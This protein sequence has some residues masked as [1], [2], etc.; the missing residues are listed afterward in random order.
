MRNTSTL[1][2]TLIQLKL[3]VLILI[4]F[5]ITQ[6][7]SQQQFKRVYANSVEKSDNEYL[8]LIKAGYVDNQN[9]AVDG[10]TST[11]ATLNS[12]V[13]QLAFIKLGGEAFVDLR[14]TGPDKPSANTPLT[15]KLGIG[16]NLLTALG[17]I[18]IQPKNGTS[19]VGSPIYGTSLLN[20]LSGKNQIEFT[21]TPTQA[22]DG[23]R[24]KLG[25]TGGILSA[26]VA[27]NLDVYHAY[28]LKPATNNIICE[29][30][31]DSLYGSTGI[32]VGSLNPLEKASN[33][34]DND[35]NTFATLRTNVSALNS[36][37]LTGV[38]SSLSKKN[39]SIRLVIQQENTGLLDLSLL[40]AIRIKTYENNTLSQNF[41]LDPSLLTLKL[42]TGGNNKYL[43]TVPTDQ[44]FNRI[45]I[46]IGD[47]VANVLAGLRVYE[48]GK[49][50]P[51][52][53]I[54]IPGLVNGS[55][56]I[57][58]G[59]PVKF[60]INNP[61]NAATYKW[62][63]DAIGGNEITTTDVTE[64]GTVFSPKNLA[65]GTYNYYVSLYRNGCSDPAS[66]RSKVTLII[67]PG[68]KSTDITA[69][70]TAICIGSDAIIAK[71][72]LAN[73][74]IQNPIF[75]W[76]LDANKT[77]PITNGT[78]NGVTYTINSD[79]SLKIS[80]LTT[81][82]D[83]YLS[84]SGTNICENASGNLKN[85]TVTVNSTEQPIL[86]LSGIQNIGT[87]GTITLTATSSN[88][89]S[90][91]WFKD[92]VSIKNSPDNSLVITNAQASDAGTYRVTATNNTNCKS[93]TSATVTINIGGFGSTK[94]V[95][96]LVDG[97]INA[98]TE[99]IF[100]I[101][102]SNTGSTPIN[103]ATISDDIPTGTS[104]VSGSADADGGVLNGNTLN[105]DLSNIIPNSTKSVSFKVK[106]N[107]NLTAISSIKNI[108]IVTDLSDP[109]N[110]QTPTVPDINTN[111]IRKFESSKTVSGLIDGK[112][113]AGAILTYNI[114]IEN[115]G[116][117]DL[118][119]ISINDVIPNGTSYIDLSADLTGGTPKANSSE[120][121][122]LI[123]VPFGTSKT[124]SF[125]V[126]V[127]DNL[128]G[129]PSI[130]NTATVTDPSDPDNPQTPTDPPKDTDPSRSFTAEKSIS[131]LNADNK[132]SPES[133]LTFDIKVKNTGN[134]DLKNI[135]ITDPIPAG[136]T[137]IED[138]ASN[139]SLINGV[140]NWLI[141]IPYNT[142]K[143]VSFKVLVAKD[144]TGIPQ[145]R[146]KATVTD[147]LHPE[148]PEEPES[149]PTDTD[150]KRSYTSTKTVTGLN[151]GKIDAGSILTYTITLTN[152]GNISLPGLKINDPIPTGTT[153]IDESANL[154]GE[155]KNN[156]L[157]WVVDLPVN[158]K[159]ELTFN[160]RVSNDL[161]GVSSIGNTATVTD[162]NDGGKTQTAVSLPEPTNQKRSFASSKVV[163]GLNTNNKITAGSTLTYK[164]NVTNTGNVNL[165]GITISD[166]IPTGTTY[167]NNSAD[168]N[169]TLTGTDLKWTI[170]VPF[171]ETKTVIFSVK[172]STD[173]TGIPSIGNTAIVTDPNTPNIPDSPGSPGNP[174]NPSV[175]NTDTEQVFDFTITSSLTSSNANGKASPGNDL[176]VSIV[177]KN[178]GNT[179]LTGIV[180]TNP[181]PN[182]TTYKSVGSNGS[183]DLLTKLF[184]FNVASLAVD[185]SITLTFNIT[186]D[187]NLANVTAITSNT[188]VKANSVE[189][190]KVASI[191]VLCPTLAATT[192]TA[193]GSNGGTLCS[194]NNNS[195]E[196]KA[197]SSGLTN[198]VYYLYQNNA[199]VDN[200][201]TGI[202]SL[203]LTPGNTTYT[204]SVG[205]SGTGYCETPAVDRK[206]ISFT[207]NSTPNAPG[208]TASNVSA[209]E[210]STPVLSIS[211]PVQGYTYA[212]YLSPSGGTSQGTG[213]NFTAAAVTGNTSYYVEAISGTCTSPTR[214]E[215]KITM[216]AAPA[217]PTNISL[218]NGP[219]CNGS[220]ARLS[221]DNPQSG[222]IYRWYASLSGGTSLFEGNIYTTD[223]LTTKT[224]YYVESVSTTT[225]C[226]SKT[227]FAI[228]VDVLPALTA[229][230]VN[231]DSKTINSVTFKW[232][233]I[234]DAIS[235]E[236]STNSGTTWQSTNGLTSYTFVGLKPAEN[237]SILVR[238]LGTNSC[239][240]S[241]ASNPAI[242]NSD[243][244]LGNE[245]FIPNTFTPNND[246]N[247]DFFLIYGNTIKTV[248]MRI[249]NQWGQSIFQ[250]QQLTT[251]WDGTYKGQNQPVG[252]YIYNIELTFNDGSNT[253]KK[254]TITLIR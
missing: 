77:T 165:T 15:I 243:N 200:N 137:Y 54:A 65:P 22:Y 239:Q 86:N 190:D 226:A 205:I 160:V 18:T 64:N 164:I 171:G 131:G 206:S 139:G 244:P 237:V 87:G 98:N 215:V 188:N 189:K 201:S 11:F 203:T 192:V 123:D 163:E 230:N 118:K 80:G 39:D 116:N 149:P 152:T 17:G 30:V 153:Y 63:T 49:I 222:L 185:A 126:K 2:K 242:G 37:F 38:Y 221:V 72:V 124:V 228:E 155:V 127:A 145:I 122:W 151:S 51:S 177:L 91:E 78:I 121:N 236:F 73:I 158:E 198:P 234:K 141:D 144:L 99:L 93:I 218:T 135:S 140:L 125:Q 142:E 181:L 96:G 50:A 95:T 20:L 249:Y 35:D 45:R 173:L 162:P 84:V 136:T 117:V 94:S 24:I 231:V 44:P 103:S 9:N 132:I 207:I 219:L 27:A 85:I 6:T 178:T 184:T 246:G 25:N 120:V 67:T 172:V 130:G 92:D 193:N 68:A 16:G 106:V 194:T 179:S 247:N 56:T 233:N 175:P 253:V 211:T 157:D 208:V 105:W 42:L 166:P 161:T 251:G 224:T 74:N 60:T 199:L 129:I 229:P 47:G 154:G 209:C 240:T 5:G 48:M 241:A 210:N 128:T 107:D 90:Y 119:D 109:G 147:P 66:A 89:V 174:Q 245:V 191:D 183:Y 170:D 53:V 76:Y 7:Y 61:E 202:F 143:I 100:T 168:N 248:N 32:L 43:L 186:A 214:T 81:T 8:L 31:I 250:S 83:Y 197:T 232:N 217:A 102:I 12:T 33:A 97:K 14:F 159:V 195:V 71:P 213:S 115:K 10:N 19:N 26:G 216:L 204:Y 36:T 225:S 235:Y 148:T 101:T 23:V 104:Y 187:M 113:K 156:A 29:S 4:T 62:F 55:L 252:V 52:P 75:K 176:T 180:V 21:I 138:P 169:G 220:E 238:A 112:I 133:E 41:T 13:V 88:A 146:N 134:V 79:L 110:P 150:P 212:W 227:R 196:I 40:S 167:V 3:S 1:K 114:K 82:R 111:Q 254:G 59:T 182:N 46:S 70:G 69:S 58:E 223:K 108:A 34:F 57:C 28:F